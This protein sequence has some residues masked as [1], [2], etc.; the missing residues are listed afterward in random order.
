MRCCLN[1]L[2]KILSGKILG[3]PWRGR[4]SVSTAAMP[5]LLGCVL[6]HINTSVLYAQE[7]PASSPPAASTLSAPDLDQSPSDQ[8][9][10]N[11][12]DGQSESAK[13]LGRREEKEVTVGENDTFLSISNAEFGTIGM[14]RLIA[15]YNKLDVS[16]PLFFGQSIY[17]PR[18]TYRPPEYAEVI[19]AHGDNKLISHTSSTEDRLQRS[20]KIFLNDIIRTGTSGFASILFRSGAVINLQPSSHVKLIKLNCLVSD[21]SCFIEIRALSGELRVDVPAASEQENRVKVITP[22]AAAAVRG[23]SFDVTT[24]DAHMLLGVT[25]GDVSAE[26]NDS[27]VDVAAGFGL[28]AVQGEPLPA[29]KSLLEAA[30]FN[31]VPVRLAAGDRVSIAPIDQAI[32]YAWSVTVDPTGNQV[33]QSGT[34]PETN[35]ELNVAQQGQ[36]YVHVRGVDEDDLKGFSST[37]AI[38]LVA[39]DDSFAAIELTATQINQDLIL[40]VVTTDPA[41]AGYE[42]QISETEDFANPVSVDIGAPG[43]LVFSQQPNTVFAR[44]RGLLT[45]ALVTPFGAAI[46]VE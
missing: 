27:A 14:W 23:T 18:L 42:V 38:E 10:S 12:T 26:A 34:Q 33:L 39:V 32:S 1:T 5:L 31:S 37:Q 43:Q 28:K 29:P 20:N 15:E 3:T 7:Q 30:S 6:T 8:P 2:R 36:Y 44:A 13:P 41:I 35:Y 4:Y 19:Y 11:T 25:E 46:A 9:L 16:K 45:P 21:D 22:H 24:S 17:I 40:D